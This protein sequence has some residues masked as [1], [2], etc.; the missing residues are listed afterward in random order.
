MS[1]LARIER[2]VFLQNAD[3]FSFCKAE[4]IFRLAAIAHEQTLE[5]GEVVYKAGDASTALYLVVR[6]GVRVEIA[7]RPARDVGPL[8]AFGVEDILCGRLRRGQATASDDSLV[9]LIEAES[10]F[11]LLSDNIEIVRA[12]FRQLLGDQ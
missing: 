2:V 8:G 9:L 1:E 10:F 4:Q 6:G 7:G 3:L 11:D 5:A 12:L